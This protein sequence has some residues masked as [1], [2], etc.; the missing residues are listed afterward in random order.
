MYWSE[1]IK[2]FSSL[3]W[4][5]NLTL[6]LLYHAAGYFEVTEN[7]NKGVKLTLFVNSFLHSFQMPFK[8]SSFT[9]IKPAIF[10]ISVFDCP[11]GTYGSVQ[12]PYGSVKVHGFNLDNKVNVAVIKSSWFN[13]N[14]VFDLDL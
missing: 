8:L 1:L 9:C 5:P 12:S 7:A 3:S 6:Y 11:C 10:A 14:F 2:D 13:S 4:G